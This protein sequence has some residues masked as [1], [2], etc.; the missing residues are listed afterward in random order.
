MGIGL[1][2]WTFRWPGLGSC[3]PFVGGECPER[4]CGSVTSLLRVP[5]LLH[6]MLYLVNVSERWRREVILILKWCLLRCHQIA[7]PH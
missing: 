1:P 4:D 3:N 5:L 7:G 6:K 2:S